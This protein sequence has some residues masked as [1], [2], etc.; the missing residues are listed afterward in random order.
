V[1]AVGAMVAFGVGETGI[2][3]LRSPN[4]DHK[5]AA[6][7]AAGSFVV[8]GTFAA[9]RFASQIGHVIAARGGRSAG[10]AVRLVATCVGMVMVLFLT[11]GLL[12]IPV[13]QLL[14]GGA[15]TG[16]ILGIAAQQSLGNVFS[17]IVLLVAKPFG[18]GSYIRI[19]SG[20][21]G[22]PFEGE[23]TALGLTYCLL[24]VDGLEMLI[25]NT[26]LLGSGVVR[27]PPKGA[28]AA[29]DLYV[30]QA[31]PKRPPRSVWQHGA[32]R[33]PA[34]QVR[35]PR[36]MVRRM[37]ERAAQSRSDGGSR[38][39][40]SPPAAAPPP[41]VFGRPAPPVRSRDSSARPPRSSGLPKNQPKDR[42]SGGRS[43]H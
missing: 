11:L 3:N 40:A 9:R 31:F 36:E 8:L 37:R 22:G 35:R 6:I 43:N 42:R 4:V 19:H 41:P 39:Q 20:S 23:V 7:A 38:P 25:P 27:L 12:R 32:A 10:A 29:R 34:S 26:Q 24:D 17:G 1:A 2:A 33:R 28:K 30:N 5:L 18:V 16:V 21:L 14:V 15:I 13:S